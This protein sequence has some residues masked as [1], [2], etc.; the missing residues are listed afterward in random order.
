MKGTVGEIKEWATHVLHGELES[1]INA[2]ANHKQPYYILLIIK[3][4]Y[5][6]PAA[7]GNNNELLHGRDKHVKPRRRKT[8]ELD[9]SKKRV[10]THRIILMNK[11][12]PLPMIGSS[13]WYINNKTGQVKCVYILPPDKPMIAGF[14]VELDSETVGKCGVNMPIFYGREN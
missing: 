1:V 7:Y 2:K 3:D 11:P 9:L 12:P 4:G 10:V 5:D 13:L 6:G 14:D 8:K